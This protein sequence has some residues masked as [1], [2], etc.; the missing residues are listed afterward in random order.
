M[1][2]G[3]TGVQVVMGTGRDGCGGDVDIGSGGRTEGGGGGDG[4]VGDGERLSRWEDN[5]AN[6]TVGTEPNAPLAYAPGLEHHHPIISTLG[7]PGG[8]LERER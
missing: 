5:V 6:L 1:E 4:W 2:T 7:E 8:R 3:A